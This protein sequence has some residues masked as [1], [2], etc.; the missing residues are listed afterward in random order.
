MVRDY[1]KY[2]ESEN[3]LGLLCESHFYSDTLIVTRYVC[4]VTF[5]GA[6][7]LKVLLIIS[8]FE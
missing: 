7:V 5:C 8:T 6:A 3:R 4:S 1:L 2:L